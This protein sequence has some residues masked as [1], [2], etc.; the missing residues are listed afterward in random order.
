LLTKHP[1]T[2]ARIICLT[3]NRRNGEA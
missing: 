2:H 1:P 3:A